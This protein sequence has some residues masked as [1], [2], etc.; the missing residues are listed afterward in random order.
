MRGREE[1]WGSR[2]QL[3]SHGG[4]LMCSVYVVESAPVKKQN[5]LQLSPFLRAD[6]KLFLF[7]SDQEGKTCSP[8]NHP[9]QSISG[10]IN[11][12]SPRVG[13]LGLGSR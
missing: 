1:C 3:E 2:E 12:L 13:V 11:S 8:V 5:S 6:F 7:C 4:E 9:Q 10:G